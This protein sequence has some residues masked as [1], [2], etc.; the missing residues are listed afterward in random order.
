MIGM[1]MPQSA[2]LT[3]FSLDSIFKSNMFSPVFVFAQACTQGSTTFCHHP[4]RGFRKKKTAMV[5]FESSQNYFSLCMQV[6]APL[7]QSEQHMGSRWPGQSASGSSTDL[8]GQHSM[9]VM[10]DGG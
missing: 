4:A 3:A 9:G 1:H 8:Q 2:G 7:S 5:S 10:E 6:G